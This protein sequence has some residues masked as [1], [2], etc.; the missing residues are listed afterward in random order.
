MTGAESLNFRKEEREYNRDFEL[1]GSYKE[2]Y[3]YNG[4]E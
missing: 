1:L 4:Y 3:N 2:F